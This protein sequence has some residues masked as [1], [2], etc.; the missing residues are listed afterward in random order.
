MVLAYVCSRIS[1]IQYQKVTDFADIGQ[2]TAHFQNKTISTLSQSVNVLVDESMQ[3]AVF[4][5]KL[6]AKDRKSTGITIMTDARHG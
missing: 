1:P 3:G 6:A 2:P 4:D 5:E